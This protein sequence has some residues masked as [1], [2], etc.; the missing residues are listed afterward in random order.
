M[1]R[2]NLLYLFA[3]AP[4]YAASS[5]CVAAH[6]QKFHVLARKK[7]QPTAV[8]FN[9]RLSGAERPYNFFVNGNCLWIDSLVCTDINQQRTLIPI[10]LNIPPNRPMDLSKH[11][12]SAGQ[13]EQ[14]SFNFVCLPLVK[15]Q[16]E[17]VVFG[18]S[19]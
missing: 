4:V 14:I 2:R 13:C 6:Q 8:K 15:S 7:L 17:I 5:V 11:F 1:N 18:L 19:V 16:T 3:G 9:V 10:G 12:Q